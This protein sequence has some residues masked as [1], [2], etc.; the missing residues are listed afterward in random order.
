MNI[1]EAIEFV[2]LNG[3]EIGK[4]ASE[5][6]E[7]AKNIVDWYCLLYSSPGDPGAQAFLIAFTEAYI[8]SKGGLEPDDA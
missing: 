8:K 3:K 6:N 1:E 7:Y 2:S 5:G 4:E